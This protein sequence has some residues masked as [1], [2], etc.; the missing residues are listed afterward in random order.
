MASFKHLLHSRGVQ[1]T[2]G[3]VPG[4]T[5]FNTLL[6]DQCQLVLVTILFYFP[7]TK[8]LIAKK[9]KKWYWF[10]FKFSKCGIFQ[11]F[12]YLTKTHPRI[13]S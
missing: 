1:I 3:H 8:T 13:L 7:V 10:N 5:S 2:A 11:S 12:L 9:K 4:V 6:E